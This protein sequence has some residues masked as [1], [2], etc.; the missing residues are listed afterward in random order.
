MSIGSQFLDRLVEAKKIEKPKAKAGYK[1]DPATQSMIRQMRD[2]GG[3]NNL[4]DK[5]AEVAAMSG[6]PGRFMNTPEGRESIVEAAGQLRSKASIVAAFLSLHSAL[7]RFHGVSVVKEGKDE[8]QDLDGV[9]FQQLVEEV[10]VALGLPQDLVSAGGKAGSKASVKRQIAELQRDSG[11]KVAYQFLAKKL[12][13]KVNDGVVGA[14][15]AGAKKPKEEAV[16]EA[17][18]QK[19]VGTQGA[20]AEDQQ[21]PS[22]AAVS[23]VKAMLKAVGV[24]LAN[25]S[26]VRVSNPAALDRAIKAALRDVSV[27]RGVQAF[28]R[29]VK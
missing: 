9:A 10:L 8:E 2:I 27:K 25:K 17:V 29:V 26:L 1:F 21:A 3:E 24:D 12:G 7:A 16:T 13:I 14:K 18:T 15:K 11:V 28:A 22:D 20:E 19:T 23:A 6:M 5:I 4:A